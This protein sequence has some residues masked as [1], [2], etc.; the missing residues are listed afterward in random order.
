MKKLT[1]PETHSEGE[2]YRFSRY[3]S[4]APGMGWGAIH[5]GTFGGDRGKQ[6]ELRALRAYVL[7]LCELLLAGPVTLPTGQLICEISYS[8]AW[9]VFGRANATS[10]WVS[11]PD[12]MRVPGIT[13]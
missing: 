8:G 7:G 2:N 6:E 13:F 1:S 12:G 10:P 9:E 4:V 11:V 3:A 5:D